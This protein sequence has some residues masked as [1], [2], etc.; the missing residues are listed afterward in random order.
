MAVIIPAKAAAAGLHG[1][2]GGSG[3]LKKWKDCYLFGSVVSLFISDI[4]LE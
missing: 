4:E 3:H 2:G 1:I